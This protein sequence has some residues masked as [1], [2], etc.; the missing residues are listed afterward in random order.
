ME[1]LA[2]DAVAGIKDMGA[3]GITCT[4]AE[5]A[6]AGNVGMDVDLA[7]VPMREEGMEPW[8]IMMSESQERMLVCVKKGRE[9]E[10][11]DIFEK[12]NL[13]AAIVGEVIEEETLW[14]DLMAK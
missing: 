12:W 6:A 10:V 8:E 9:Q 13:S 14:L 1:L 3:A 4:T 5:M 2:G 11:I 7:K